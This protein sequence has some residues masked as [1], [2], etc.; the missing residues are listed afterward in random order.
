MD[1]GTA[2]EIVAFATDINQQLANLP[3]SI[4]MSDP[5][6]SKT[7]RREVH[8]K[9]VQQILSRYSHDLRKATPHMMMVLDSELVVSDIDFL[10][11]AFEPQICQ[12]CNVSG[13][14]RMTTKT[15][16]KPGIVELELMCMKCFEKSKH[17]S[18]SHTIESRFRPKAWLPN[19]LLLSFLL[20][21]EY[22]K[23]Y[24]HVLGTPGVSHLSKSQWIHVVKWVHPHVKD[25]AQWSCDEINR[26]IARQDDQKSLEIMYDGFYLTRGYHAN[27]ASGTIHDVKSGKIVAFAHRSRGLGSNWVG[28]SGGAEGDIFEELLTGLKDKHFNVKECT[29]DH[30]TTCANV[31]LEQFPE[32]EVIYCG[33]H[34]IKTFH[35]D[36]ANIKK[37]SCQVRQFFIPSSVCFLAN[38]P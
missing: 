15:Q 34:T 23:G 12:K 32:A 35:S 9:Q 13:Q 2:D 6:E 37:I 7:D 17:N 8:T 33:N 22:F 11:A 5:D 19:Y 10:V 36:L 29:I 21:G 25:L 31:L 30:D 16:V 1:I 20:N 3:V 26:E 4:G 38:V 18:D 24:E 28:T 14:L 27:N